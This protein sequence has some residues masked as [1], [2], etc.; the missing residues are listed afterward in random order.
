MPLSS[1]QAETWY[2]E[3]LYTALNHLV[4]LVL[5]IQRSRLL[6][7][8]TQPDST[9][10]YP[11]RPRLHACRIFLPSTAAADKPSSGAKLPLVILVH[12]GGWA[13]NTPSRDDPLARYLADHAGCVAVAID[14]SKAPGSRFPVA[15]EDVVALTSAV[16]DDAELRV[17]KESVVLIGNSAGGNL[18]LAA[19]QDERLRGRVKGVLG[20]YPGT[21]FT[22]TVAE[23]VATATRADAE[24]PDMLESGAPKMERMY[25]GPQRLELE[26]VRLSPTFFK[27]R[28]DL[29]EKVWLVGCEFDLLCREAEVMAERLAM[30]KERVGGKDEWTVGGVRWTRVKG[31]THG[32]DQ[33]GVRGKAHEAERLR[34]RAELWGK[35][36]EWLGEVFELEGTS[37]VS[38][39]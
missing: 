2:T 20:L 16:I 15:Y 26:D 39:E 8:G 12:G 1:G 10:T 36:V 17:D 27:W 21:D 38:E 6:A 28:A 9:K 33:F 22:T 30:G 14:Y 3:V 11:C 32:F 23:K 24:K 31:Q 19:T 5:L 4:A 29:P 37:K 35:M 34:A 13:I 18:V 25:I 7:P